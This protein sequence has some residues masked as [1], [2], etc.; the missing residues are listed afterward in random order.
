MAQ[1]RM[2]SLKIVDTD[3]FLDMPLSTQSLYFHLAMRADDDGFVSNPKKILRM[4]GCQDDDYK[5][6]LTKRFILPFESGV[7]VIKHWRI[8]NL[9]RVDRYN[10]TNYL[11][12]KQQLVEKPNKSYTERQKPNV[13]PNGN[14][15][16]PQVRLGKVSIDNTARKR[17]VSTKKKKEKKDEPMSKEEFIESCRK[18]P[19]RYINLIGEYADE[20][21]SVQFTTKE[22]WRS[23]LN[24]NLRPAKA[25]EPYTND[26]I[27][28]AMKNIESAEYIKR[29][30]M[31]TLLK[32][33]EE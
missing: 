14:Q 10:E 17:E 8:H 19:Q 16:E 31:E 27:G 25:L 32:Y 26:Q 9:I 1:R 3:A 21:K 5:V 20:K 29:W 24:R 28:K 7:C 4:I 33:L 12:E 22:Q 23:F 15:W 11:E 13:I 6:L 18:S 2:F 30:T